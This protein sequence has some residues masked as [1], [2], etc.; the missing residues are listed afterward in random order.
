MPTTS[1][2]RI[3]NSAVA[4]VDGQNPLMCEVGILFLEKQRWL[5]GTTQIPLATVAGCVFPD[6]LPETPSSPLKETHLPTIH[7]QVLTRC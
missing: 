6:T 4:T 2:K 3:T 1:S 5:V 7:F